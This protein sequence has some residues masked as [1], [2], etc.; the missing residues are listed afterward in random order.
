MKAIKAE[1]MWE[2]SWKACMCIWP[3]QRSDTQTDV[4]EMFWCFSKTIAV[5]S[6]YL[7]A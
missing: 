4:D 1:C 2:P 7:P 3:Q 5:T 6:A